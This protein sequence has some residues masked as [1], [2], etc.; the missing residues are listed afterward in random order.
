MDI[1]SVLSYLNKISLLA[2][3]V[4]AGFLGYQFYLLKKES[5]ANKNK[6]P[7]IPDFNENEKIDVLNY[8]KLPGSLTPEHQT[9][10][11]KD[12]RQAIT[13]AAG[14]GLLVLTLGVFIILKSKQ[15]KQ[16][17]QVVEPTPT[18]KPVVLI[19]KQPTIKPSVTIT[20]TAVKTITVTPSTS[21]T[22]SPT[23]VVVALISPTAKPSA[24]A[25]SGELSPT[26]ISNLPVTGV[27]DQ[28]LIFFGV[29]ASLIF[30]AF[31]F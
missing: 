3:V 15:T 20:P 27:I 6:T 17:S 12:N 10:T 9:V 25:S 31:V 11:R 29:A 24:G 1:F 28:S 4:T 13:F 2:F 19:S 7:A 23:E 18:A 26:T 30:F 5:S 14:A 21:S 22:P 16:V 8:T